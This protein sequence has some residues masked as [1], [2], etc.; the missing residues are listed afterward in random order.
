M[1]QINLLPHR[2]QHRR[3]QILQHVM[4]LMGAVGLSL[5]LCAGASLYGGS[6][7]A[8]VEEKLTSLRAQNKVLNNKLG[9]IRNL[10]KLRAD[11]RR[12]LSLIDSLQH[13]RFRSL[14]TLIALSRAIPGNVW[15]LNFR[16]TGDGLHV[17]GMSDS[18][19]AVAGFMRAL[20]REVIFTNVRLRMIVRKEIGTVPVRNFSLEI[21][22]RDSLPV[23]ARNMSGSRK[24]S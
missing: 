7:L 5:L 17:E 24:R 23:T 15:L 6:T 18:N 22:Q 12:K 11:V 3:H 19:K 14:N 10:D 21:K 8:G 20:D 1:M 2:A 9:Q 13:G 16:D 4:A